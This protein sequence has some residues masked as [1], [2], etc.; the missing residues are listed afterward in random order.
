MNKANSLTLGLFLSILLLWVIFF[1]V[2]ISDLIAVALVIFIYIALH[3]RLKLDGKFFWAGSLIGTAGIEIYVLWL[4]MQTDPS[5]FDNSWL[6]GI[7]YITPAIA[8]N[9]IALLLYGRKKK[10]AQVGKAMETSAGQN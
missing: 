9:A 5:F 6:N 10:E 2:G 1:Y 7:L 8:I 4:A 3:N